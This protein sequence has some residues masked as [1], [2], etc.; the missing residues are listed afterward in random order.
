MAETQ[1]KPVDDAEA[2][3]PVTAKLDKPLV[4]DPERVKLLAELWQMSEADVI[5]HEKARLAGKK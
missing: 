4:I 1:K 2:P 3:A 5:A